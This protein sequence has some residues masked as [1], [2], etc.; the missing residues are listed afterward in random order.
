M[1]GDARI[2]REELIGGMTRRSRVQ[3]SQD[4]LSESRGLRAE[5]SIGFC[6]RIALTVEMI[7]RCVVSRDFDGVELNKQYI[8]VVCVLNAI[9]RKF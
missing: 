7:V 9:V 4:L 5:R 3:K 6:A 1:A 2:P 8:R